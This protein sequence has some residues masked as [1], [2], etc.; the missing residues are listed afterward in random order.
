MN[1]SR[2]PSRT[3]VHVADL[4]L[5]AVVLHQLIG[6]QHVAADLAAEGDVLLG[7]ADLIELGLLLFQLQVVEPGPQH[8]HGH[9]AV[10]VL[11]PLVLARDHDAGRQVGDA[12]R[13]VG[14]VDVLAAGAARSVG[15]DPQVLLVD[16]DVDVVLDLGPDVDRGERRVAARR[17]VERR[18]AHQAVDAG[19]G[20][21]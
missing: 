10:L 8:L 18:D 9:V 19:L 7:A 11:R 15:V 12:H 16:V 6:L 1:P 17:L 2:S 4:H 3:A 5:G 14:L 20:C 21:N 13:R